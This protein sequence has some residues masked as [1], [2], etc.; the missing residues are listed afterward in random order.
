MFSSISELWVFSALQPA[1][2]LC[3][4]CHLMLIPALEGSQTDL[5]ILTFPSYTNSSSLENTCSEHVGFLPTFAEIF[6]QP[7]KNQAASCKSSSGL[8]GGGERVAKG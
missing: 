6:F 8:G 5:L 1:G 2:L 3:E 7:F 4:L